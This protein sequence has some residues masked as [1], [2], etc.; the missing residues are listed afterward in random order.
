MRLCTQIKESKLSEKGN[1]MKRKQDSFL[2]DTLIVFITQMSN[3]ILMFLINLLATKKFGAEVYG[4]YIYYITTLSFIIVICK[5]G[6]DQGIIAYLPKIQDDKKK[7][8]SVVGFAYLFTV[9]ISIII[10]IVAWNYFTIINEELS[11]FNILLIFSPMVTIIEVSGGIFRANNLI[12]RYVLIKNVI[13]NIIQLL[14]IILCDVNSISSYYALVIVCGASYSISFIIIIYDIF[15]KNVASNINK[16]YINDYKMLFKISFPLLLA[17]L[18]SMMMNRIDIFFINKYLTNTDIAIYNAAMKIANL[19]LF[20]VSVVN[21]TLMP[22]LAQ[23]FHAGKILEFKYIYKETTKAVYVIALMFLGGIS[24]FGNYA[25]RIFD[26]SFEVAFIPLLIISIAN[27]CSAAIGVTGYINVIY[28]NSK[29]EMNN[30]FLAVIVSFLFNMILV[31]HIG[32]V[33]AAISFLAASL[34]LNSLRVVITKLKYGIQPFDWEFIWITLFYMG[35]IIVVNVFLENIVIIIIMY[36]IFSLI[37]GIYYVIKNKD[38]FVR[39]NYGE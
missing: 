3:V 18:C 26:N 15:T 34:T 12:K 30:T 20:V 22:K 14:I 31:K 7:S 35:G 8:K 19:S 6:I 2:G 32:I 39:R 4:E 16:K 33:G 13:I 5:M 25:L 23:L 21:I 17:G 24:L 36:I 10:T 29:I 27:V 28:G 11:V 1:V 37:L 38:F 9:I